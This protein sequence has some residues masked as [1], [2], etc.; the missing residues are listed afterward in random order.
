MTNIITTFAILN[1]SCLVCY[2]KRKQGISIFLVS[3]IRSTSEHKTKSFNAICHITGSICGSI[4]TINRGTLEISIFVLF[5][6]CFYNHCSSS[7]IGN[8]FARLV[9]LA[10]HRYGLFSLVAPFSRL[11]LRY[12]S[13]CHLVVLGRI[14]QRIQ[15]LDHV[16][17]VIAFGCFLTNTEA[18]KTEHFCPT[19]GNTQ[20][21]VE[22]R[23]AFGIKS[24]KEY[25][26]IG[27]FFTVN[28]QRFSFT[29]NSNNFN[30]CF[31]CFFDLLC[32]SWIIFN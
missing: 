14:C 11:A 26:I 18:R 13:Q 28:C 29:T 1:V 23:T 20:R 22:F 4:D 21:C 31:S 19:F 24:T 3:H 17:G 12:Y 30:N 9:F 32:H 10:V 25:D 15:F 8:E 5:S 27:I 2:R 16:S 7:T 6:D